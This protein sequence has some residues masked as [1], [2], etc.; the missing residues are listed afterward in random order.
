MYKVIELLLSVFIILS[1]LLSVLYRYRVLQKK[2]GCNHCFKVLI[3]LVFW[4]IPLRRTLKG[5]CKS[6]N[7]LVIR[8]NIYL[9][10]FLGLSI[11]IV[12]LFELWKPIS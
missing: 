1:F 10:L 9:G 12:I 4:M 8:S 11:L 7:S 6:Y 3:N 2:E 5:N